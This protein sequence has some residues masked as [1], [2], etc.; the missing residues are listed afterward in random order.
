MSTHNIGFYEDL[1]KNI[2]QLSSDMHFCYSQFSM[3]TYE[4]RRKKTCFRGF[5]TRSDTNRAVQSQEIARG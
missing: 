3:K 2:F 1:T 5:R 4:P